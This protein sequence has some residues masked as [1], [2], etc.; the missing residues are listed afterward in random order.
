M[1]SCVVAD[2]NEHFAPFA[3]G[4]GT[5]FQNFATHLNMTAGAL[6]NGALVFVAGG[7][8]SGENLWLATPLE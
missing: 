6:F 4:H 5:V 8:A 3:N 7:P 1:D 2:A